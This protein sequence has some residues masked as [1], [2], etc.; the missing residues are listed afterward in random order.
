MIANTM[1]AGPE[2]GSHARAGVLLFLLTTLGLATAACG[3]ART[4][5][6]GDA[7]RS[8]VAGGTAV[9]CSQAAPE[10]LNPFVSPDQGARDLA[11][12]LFTP[13]LRY[14]EADGVRPHLARSWS[15]SPD[16]RALTLHLRTDVVWHD[17]APV[18][19]GDVVWT[20]ERA[21]DPTFGY[22]GGGG[23]SG[24]E[25]AGAPDDSTAVLRFRAP[26]PAGLEPLVHLPVLP[27]HL[28]A[29]AADDDPEG[30]RRADYHRQPVGSGPF[31]LQER[32]GDGTLIF[33]RVEGYPEELGRPWLDRIAFRAIAEPGA[34]VAELEAGGVDA[35]VGGAGL[36]AT[37]ARSSRVRTLHV[38]PEGAQVMVLNTDRPPLDDV[39]VRR[40]LSEAV[41]RQA[42]AAVVSPLAQPAGAAL[43]PGSP[44]H[45]ASLTMSEA[46][47]E[48]AAALLEEAGWTA[49]AGGGIRR[50]ADGKELRLQLVAPPQLEPALTA[51]QAHLSRVGVGLEL[52][53]MEFAAL[54]PTI[55]NPST[56]PEAVA[57]GFYDDRRL[58]P[59]YYDTFHSAGERN[60]AGYASPEVDGI[61]ERLREAPDEEER[62]TLYRELQER[63][64]EDVPVV[65]TVYV[66]RTLAVGSRLRGLEATPEGP[67][68]AA[69]EW[70]RPGGGR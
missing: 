51:V 61:L 34:L 64:A 44:F 43:T 21:A 50:N 38:G 6:T 60:I 39:R 17:G 8:P 55:M 3:E 31:R 11:P 69:A 33:Q 68:A 2:R 54:I 10:A 36:A 16:G 13:L 1:Q 47:P 42:V 45:H 28:L 56:R 29:G 41:D 62:E 19:A 24:L 48:R 35:C 52:R 5:G 20:A 27:R 57:L 18:T 7:E 4:E 59:D 25:D 23:L 26:P 46:R 53:F 12:L 40:A 37:A 65:Y 63:L 22:P 66:P 9:I 32:R 67:F 14:D 30:F 58:Y 15:W 49:P 70:W